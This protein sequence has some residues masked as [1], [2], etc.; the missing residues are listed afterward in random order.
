MLLQPLR[1]Q[2]GAQL[3]LDGFKRRWC[4]IPCVFTL[5][6]MPA[7]LGLYRLV[8]EFT[9]GHGCYRS[10][11]GSDHLLRVEPA[12]IASAVFRTRILGVLFGQVGKF[13][14]LFQFF[15]Q[16]PCLFFSFN[17][18][19]TGLVFGLLVGQNLLVIR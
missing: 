2:H 9:I 3:I 14:A 17:Q 10:R 5:N 19:V 18:D 4:L 11:E 1:L 6:D 8:R 13:I 16:V 7:K 15:D 12:Q